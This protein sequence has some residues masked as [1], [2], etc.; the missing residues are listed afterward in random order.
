MHYQ[1]QNCLY[2]ERRDFSHQRTLRRSPFLVPRNFPS[3]VPHGR[4]TRHVPAGATRPRGRDAPT[5]LRSTS[6]GPGV[7]FAQIHTGRA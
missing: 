1:F 6:S 5:A 2:G 7:V 4:K 3:P